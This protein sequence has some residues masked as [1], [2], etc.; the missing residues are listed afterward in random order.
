MLQLS[1]NAPMPWLLKMS[2][3]KSV[4]GMNIVSRK[5]SAKDGNTTA[6]TDPHQVSTILRKSDFFIINIFFNKHRIKSFQVEI[7]PISCLNE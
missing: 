2:A 1:I 6:D 3:N 7:W 4:E 5:T